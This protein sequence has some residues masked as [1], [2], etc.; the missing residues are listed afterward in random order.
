MHP[1]AFRDDAADRTLEQRRIE[2]AALIERYA[3]ADGTHATAFE[4]LVLYRASTPSEPIHSTYEPAL[5]IVAQGS[6]QVLLADEL[7]RYD[8]ANFLLVSVDLPIVGQVVD[9][10]TH[11]PYL[12][13]RLGLDPGQ[14]GA[15]IVEA[16]LPAPGSRGSGRALAVGRLDA[17][18][19]DAV[20]RLLGLLETPEHLRM[21]APPIVREILYRLLVGDQG[22][23]LRHLARGN[24]QTQRIGKA[25]DL[26]K[27]R[28]AEPLRIDDLASAANMSAS[29]LHHHF[30]AVTAMS[31]LQYQ[32]HLRL[33]EAR[34]LMLGEDL[35]AAT[36][37]FRVGYESPSQFSREYRRLFGAP[38][39]RDIT[40]LRSAPWTEARAESR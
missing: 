35:D 40:R 37:G 32:K 31:P 34:R 3:R 6:K 11:T 17:A 25:I 12:G 36:A 24:G 20:V 9:A 33:Q 27:R 22:D 4:P 26:L 30:K 21:L 7:Y 19:V 18:L 29:G 10:S 14:I 39:L 13:L 15:L 1:R 16:D 28:F 38:P 5:C 23:R 2:L 8:P